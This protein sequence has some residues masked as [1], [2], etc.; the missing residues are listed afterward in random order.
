MSDIRKWDRY[1]TLRAR[2]ANRRLSIAKEREYRSLRAELIL[3]V[4][5]DWRTST[6][7]MLDRQYRSA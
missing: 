5:T 7:R 1:E 3:N 2:R 6:E 4:P